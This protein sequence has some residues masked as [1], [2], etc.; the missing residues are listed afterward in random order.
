MLVHQLKTKQIY[1]KNWQ[2]QKNFLNSKKT[3]DKINIY[4]IYSFGLLLT[5]EKT[6]FVWWIFIL[7]HIYH[8]YFLFIW[9]LLVDIRL[10]NDLL[11]GNLFYDVGLQLRISDSGKKKFKLL[12][13][14]EH[15][16]VI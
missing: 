2:S 5:V 7:L 14:I 12:C 10:I 15:I 4:T 3:E 9:I 1:S 16:Q 13:W 6:L 11:Y 8:R